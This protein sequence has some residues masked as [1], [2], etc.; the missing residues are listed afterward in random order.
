MSTIEKE[1]D[2]L[3]RIVIPKIFRKK[4]GIESNSKV[5]IGLENDRIFISSP[6]SRCA[7]CGKKI[8]EHH[9]IKLCDSCIAI[10]RSK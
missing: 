8:S 1:V 6:I 3:G 10:V 5:L 2:S 4:L 9:N 7:L